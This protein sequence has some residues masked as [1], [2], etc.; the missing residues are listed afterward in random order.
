MNVDT[1]EGEGGRRDGL[2]FINY[3]EQRRN[4]SN[5][6]KLNQLIKWITGIKTLSELGI[7]NI[8]KS[9]KSNNPHC[10]CK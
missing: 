7:I 9:D 10:H 8:N 1:V 5:S 6:E 2:H 4:F 3:P